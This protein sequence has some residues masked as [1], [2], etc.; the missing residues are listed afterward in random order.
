M[1][2]DHGG[3]IA[4]VTADFSVSLNPLGPPDCLAG[5][6]RDA[7]PLITRY[8]SLDARPARCSLAAFLGL[9]PG[10]VLVGNGATELISL[11]VRTLRPGRVWVIEPC[12]SEYRGAAE[13]CGIPVAAVTSRVV[14]GSFE[15]V[16]ETL[17]P[18]PGDVVFIGYPN[19][20]TG[21]LPSPDALERLRESCP[22]VYWVFDESFLAF[23]DPARGRSPAL[24]PMPG[25]AAVCSL[26]KF[27]AV[28]GLRLGYL[29][30]TGDLVQRLLAA[31]D[32]WSVNGLGEHLVGR[33]LADTAYAEKTR[34]FAATERERVTAALV[35]LGLRVFRGEA[36]FLLCELPDGYDVQTLNACLF[37]HDMAVRDASTFAGLSTRHFRMG[38]R[39]AEQNDRLLEVLSG[40]LR[41]ENV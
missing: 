39:R 21:Q 11:L 5:L 26:T 35:K 10:E 31:K 7:L 20:P 1:K 13:A 41:G 29:V 9:D 32:P 38:L 6:L 27:Y 3:N 4:G 22:G 40:F 37:R 17:T 2:W 19:N 12:Y 15:P 16:W 14:D 25:V 18:V 8:P 24:P 23:V 34:D 36:N 33:L 30:G 28:P